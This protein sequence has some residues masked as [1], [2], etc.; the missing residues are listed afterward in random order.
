[1]TVPL[2]GQKPA[3]Q[4][5]SRLRGE[6]PPR[7]H[8]ILSVRCYGQQLDIEVPPFVLTMATSPAL[9]EPFAFTSSL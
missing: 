6:L 7:S 3:P 4:I 5:L 8:K 1:M 9:M 2:G